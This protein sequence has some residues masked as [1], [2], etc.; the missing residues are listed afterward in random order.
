VHDGEKGYATED[1]GNGAF[2]AVEEI[3]ITMTGLLH[4]RKRF[5]SGCPL[6]RPHICTEE[7]NENSILT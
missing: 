4:G 6:S 7:D 5:S 1:E 3:G 2:I